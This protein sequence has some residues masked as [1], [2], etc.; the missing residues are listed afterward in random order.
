MRVK[1]Y[2]IAIEREGDVYIASV[3]A[4][5]GC[6]LVGDTEEEAVLGLG[7]AIDGWIAMAHKLGHKVPAPQR[8]YA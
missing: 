5:P 1:G 4:L 3:P 6:S 8:A 2:E 7:E